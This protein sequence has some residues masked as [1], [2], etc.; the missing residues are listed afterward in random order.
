MGERLIVERLAAVISLLAAIGRYFFLFLLYRFLWQ[1]LK[2]TGGGLDAVRQRGFSIMVT[3]LSN[4]ASVQRYSLENQLTVGRNRDNQII[5]NDPYCSG[6]HLRLWR[7]GGK[8][9]AEDLESTFGTLVSGIP[10]PKMTPVEIQPGA[11]IMIGT[12][13]L[14]LQTEQERSF[15]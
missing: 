2:A 14:C 3:D 11:K 4:P 9:F 6:K 5:L 8:V 10:L 12:S 1:L 7:K 15:N 13:Q